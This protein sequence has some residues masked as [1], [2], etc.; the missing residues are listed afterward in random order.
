MA[1][2]EKN[3]NGDG[4]VVN[5]PN[6]QAEREAAG[7]FDPDGKPASEGDGQS[8][9][10]IEKNGG[11]DEEDDGQF[12][13]VVEEQGRR[14]TLGTLI[15]RGTPVEYRVTMG[16][17]SVGARGGLIDPNDANILLVVRGV[18]SNVDTKFT[19]DD[20]GRITKATIYMNIAPKVVLPA[21]SEAAKVL[22]HGEPV[23]A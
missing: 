13:F 1:D 17:K 23:A 12:A 2:I 22:L 11:V 9:E 16:S 18:I 14:I 19:R 6:N 15:N 10:D 8:L 20:D 7:E 3:G 21:A 5:L 4:N